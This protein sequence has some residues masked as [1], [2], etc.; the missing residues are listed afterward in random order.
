MNT[1]RK[2][3]LLLLLIVASLQV[4]AQS[5]EKIDSTKT[6]SY[7]RYYDIGIGRN[8]DLHNISRNSMSTFK[9]SSDVFNIGV[10]SKLPVKLGNVL[11]G[12]W[13]F[14]TTFLHMIW[15]HEFGHSLRA[16]QIGGQFDIHNSSL[17]V[18]LTT[19]D[20]PANVTNIDCALSVTAGFEVNHLISS[21]I[22]NDFYEYNGVY[23]DELALSFANRIMFTVYTSLIVR[24]DP[25]DK[26]TWLETA[27]DPVH[28]I[29]PVWQ[30]Y[31]NNNIFETDSTVNPGLVKFYNQSV[32]FGTFW[33]LADPFFYKQI[34]GTFGDSK[35][36]KKP[37]FALGDHTTGWTFGTMFNMS[38]L[39]YELYFNNYVRLKEKSLNVSFK[40]GRPFKNNSLSIQCPNIFESKTFKVGA[41][42]EVWDQDIFGA[43]FSAVS[44][45]SYRFSKDLFLTA[46]AGYKTDGYT[47]G[48]AIDENF[49]LW[50][51]LQYLIE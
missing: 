13:G 50:L 28:I 20:L 46:E 5:E 7:H 25:S 43:G 12:V 18:P 19:M 47:L 21:S 14:S 35:Y 24:R 49:I 41:K 16:R 17:P 6:P 8:F 45:A 38:P 51:G 10:R 30:E 27:G 2:L 48:R 4:N 34:I 37:W 3:A 32:I 44:N 36:G 11:S 31:S 9:V 29:H 22:Q 39:G 33:N 1:N 23:N 40:Y 42:A 26:E 15:P